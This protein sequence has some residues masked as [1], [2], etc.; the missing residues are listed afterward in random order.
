MCGVGEGEGEEEGERERD[1]LWSSGNLQPF[2]L[3]F[4]KMILLCFSQIIA[5]KFE[6]KNNIKSPT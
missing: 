5:H 2:S 4:A 3:L 1:D 6:N